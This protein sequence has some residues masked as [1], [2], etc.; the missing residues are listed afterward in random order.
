MIGR[1]EERIVRVEAEL[2]QSKT[3]LDEALA[4]PIK[5]DPF[6]GL[7]ASLLASSAEN[8]EKTLAELKQGHEE[9]VSEMKQP[10]KAYPEG[11]LVHKVNTQEPSIG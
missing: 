9:F 8:S 7:A 2:Q 10:S 3:C 4:T 5:G 1:S 6:S 11:V